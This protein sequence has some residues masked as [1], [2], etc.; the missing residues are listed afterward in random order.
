MGEACSTHATSEKCIQKSNRE[1]AGIV[2]GTTNLDRTSIGLKSVE[3]INLAPG[4]LRFVVNSAVNLR[5]AWEL[6][7]FS[8]SCA[9]ASFLRRISVCIF[10]F[11]SDLV[12]PFYPLLG[13]FNFG[14]SQWSTLPSSDRCDCC[15][16]GSIAV[17]SAVVLSVLT[18]Q[19]AC[20][21]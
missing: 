10:V 8:T 4:W 12:P 15:R 20:G 3:W 14:R 11:Q 17:S 21:K 19:E 9:T 1:Y 18:E 7:D 13:S 5:I 2:G 16:T 6:A